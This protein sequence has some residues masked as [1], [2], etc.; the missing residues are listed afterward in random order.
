MRLGILGGSFNPPH[1]GH[2]R[3]ALG[4][5]EHLK[6]D[7]VMMVPAADPPHKKLAYGSPEPAK[8]L[9]MCRLRQG[10]IL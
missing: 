8:R 2:I 4:A 9:E 10:N 1:P 3:Y 6:L 7:K 5:A